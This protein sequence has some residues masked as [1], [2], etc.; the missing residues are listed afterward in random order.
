MHEAQVYTIPIGFI[1]IFHHCLPVS[2][3]PRHQKMPHDNS[4]LH[5]PRCIKDRQRL[6]PVHFPQRFLRPFRI[7]RRTNILLCPCAVHKLEIIEVNVDKAVQQPDL[8]FCLVATAVD[9]I[10]NPQ[11][12]VP[13]LFHSHHNRRQVVVRCHQVNVVGAL[14]LECQ[15]NVA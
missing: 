10:G 12:P 14:L 5:L 11:P 6:L 13:G 3:H 1:K 4:L 8:R 2:H 9:D 15:K 7:V